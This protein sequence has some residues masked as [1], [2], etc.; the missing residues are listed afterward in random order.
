MRANLTN[1]NE[2]I[3]ASIRVLRE[4]FKT[5]RPANGQVL[6]GS[7]LRR[8]FH[9]GPTAAAGGLRKLLLAHA[10]ATAEESKQV[11]EER[12][13]DQCARAATCSSHA[14]RS[15]NRFRT[16]AHLPA[17]AFRR[18][19]PSPEQC[20]AGGRPPP[21]LC[22]DAFMASPTRAC[23]ANVSISYRRGSFRVS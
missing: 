12:R 16:S 20:A 8:A 6:L 4:T 13:S 1:R 21:L 2:E 7:A 18:A 23:C 22:A 10:A 9:N 19:V 17:R 5:G 15:V 14:V 3:L 11:A